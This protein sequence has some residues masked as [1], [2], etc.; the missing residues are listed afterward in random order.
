MIVDL[1]PALRLLTVH[2]DTDVELLGRLQAG[3]EEAFVTLVGRY[4]PSMLR[5]A[6]GFVPTRAVA[7]E[8][9]QETWLGVVRGVERFEGRSTFKVWLFRIL[10]NQA[11]TAGV[12]EK[13]STPVDASGPALD[14][15]RFGTDGAW[16]DPP[17]QWV[18]DTV[19]R[20]VAGALS[21]Q[22][23]AALDDLPPRQRDVVVLRD[24]EELSSQDVCTI[25]GLSEANQR[26][27]LH[28]GRVKLRDALESS[29][30]ER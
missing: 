2:S 19:D 9:V 11:K 10:V 17:E 23:L 16:V 29:F 5:V 6:L 22:L 27:L 21:S 8:A 13:R 3:D 28:R 24:V 1:A 20:V 25:L 15:A 30:R 26:V 12:K 14:A 7:E 4:Q 18:E